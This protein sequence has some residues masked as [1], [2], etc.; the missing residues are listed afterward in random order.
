MEKLLRF[1]IRAEKDWG[2]GDRPEYIFT[3]SQ[4]KALKALFTRAEVFTNVNRSEQTSDES[5]EAQTQK[6]NSCVLEFCIKLLDHQ[7]VDNKYK[8]ALISGLAVLGVREDMGWIDVI[9]YTLVYSGIIKLARL[10]VIQHT[11]QT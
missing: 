3:Y 11:H 8:S 6:L 9:D 1:I 10:M 4:K 5:Q 2:E 7:L